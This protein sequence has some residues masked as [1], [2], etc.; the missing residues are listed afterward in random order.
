[1]SVL[2]DPSNAAGQD[3]MKELKKID[4][5]LGD[6]IEEL[7]ADLEKKVEEGKTWVEKTA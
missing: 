5:E 1:M 2:S 4:E 7:E 6:E 3:Q